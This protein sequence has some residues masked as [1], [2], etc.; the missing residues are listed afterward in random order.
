MRRM[1]WREKDDLDLTAEDIDAMIVEGHEVTVRGPRGDSHADG[2]LI[3]IDP[4]LLTI[5]GNIV[6]PGLTLT[7]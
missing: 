1:G 2:F 7:R 6:R 4:H 3:D 5:T